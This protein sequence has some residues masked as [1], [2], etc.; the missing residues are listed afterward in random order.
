MRLEPLRWR[1]T[2]TWVW[3]AYSLVMWLLIPFLRLKLHLR[4]RHEPGYLANIAQR[5]GHYSRVESVTGALWIHA[6]SLGETRA[7]GLLLKEIREQAP[8]I[9]ILLTHGTATGLEAGR[10]W[11]RP[12]DMQVWQP[13]DTPGATERFIRYFRPAMGVLMETEVWPNLVRS[14]HEQRV[15]LYL[16]NARLNEKSHR[17]AKRLIHLS[18]PAYSGLRAVVAQ[19]EHDARRLGDLG[20][21]VVG[22]FGNLKFD[23]SPDAALTEC[24]RRWKSLAGPRP[25]VMLASTREG[26]EN[27]WLQHLS[28]GTTLANVLW[29]V[30]PRHP[31]RFDAVVKLIEAQGYRVFRRSRLDAQPPSTTEAEAAQVWVGDTL[32]EMAAYYAMADVAWL[33]GSYLPFG[34]QNLIEA[35]AQSCPVVMGPH[36]YNFAD[37]A[38]QALA[39]GAAFRVR[40]MSEAETRTRQLL[41]DRSAL[42]RARQSCLTLLHQG[43][44]SVKRYARFL[45]REYAQCKEA[46]YDA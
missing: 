46:M 1:A 13:W 31:Q 38:Q 39:V 10:A 27:L 15:P 45:L 22:V 9:K 42:Q 43:Q 20:A 5:L 29:L 4:G 23:A 28:K 12:G 41:E 37:A 14:A 19:T 32:G 6:V 26:E 16:V 7:A 36:T 24:G 33:G 3:R 2:E 21:A 35:A 25:V 44:G 17:T 8:D 30:V 40:D 34:G 11:L 18:R